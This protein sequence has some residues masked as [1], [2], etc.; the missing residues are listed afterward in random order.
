MQFGMEELETRKDPES[1]MQGNFY[2]PFLLRRGNQRWTLSM[3][4]FRRGTIQRN[5]YFF[6]FILSLLQPGKPKGLELSWIHMCKSSSSQ[7]RWKV[8]RKRW[9]EKTV[10]L[11]SELSTSKPIL[12][13]ARL[14]SPPLHIR[15]KQVKRIMP[16][17]PVLLL[18]FCPCYTPVAKVIRGSY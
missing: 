2:D 8:I 6:F 16:E 7:R 5:S 10:S 4:Y 17:Q 15:K 12:R 14:F 9:S 11:V 1:C 18:Y 13:P 3:K